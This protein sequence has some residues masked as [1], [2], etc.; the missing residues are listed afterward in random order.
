MTVDPER[1]EISEI[2]YMNGKGPLYRYLIDG[3][4][5]VSFSES[6]LRSRL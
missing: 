5:H 6:Q 4:R 3:Y 1:K 2:V